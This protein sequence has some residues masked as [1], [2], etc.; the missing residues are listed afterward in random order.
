[1]RLP[2]HVSSTIYNSLN[3]R[4]IFSRF[5]CLVG[6][7]R[8]VCICACHYSLFLTSLKMNVDYCYTLSLSL[9]HQNSLLTS[10]GDLFVHIS[11]SE[12]LSI[13]FLYRELRLYFCLISFGTG[14]LHSH[15]VALSENPIRYRSLGTNIAFFI[16]S[17]RCCDL[18]WNHCWIWRSLCG[19]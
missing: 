6:R 12:K 14:W 9:L 1:M 18:Q 13:F 17:D 4:H 11:I 3:R 19:N 5:H 16:F 7:G 8:S 15:D 2:I 10:R